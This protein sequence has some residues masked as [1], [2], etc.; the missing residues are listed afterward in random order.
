MVTFWLAGLLIAASAVGLRRAGYGWWTP[1][2]IGLVGVGLI[3]AG[4]FPTDP[5][6][7]Y[8]PSSPI[9]PP[10]TASG[11]AHSLFST[12]VFTA[13][14]AAMLVMARRLFRIGARRWAWYSL[15]SAPV[16]FGCFVMSSLGFR[17]N[18]MV[19]PFGGL[20][21]RLAL[22]VGLGWLAAVALRLRRRSLTE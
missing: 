14:P 5:I 13:L 15:L 22:I 21:Q 19:M 6:S 11:T 2:L 12:P 3:G 20:W 4:I 17:Q 7:G 10:T 9:P 16:F 1:I 18:L 8:P